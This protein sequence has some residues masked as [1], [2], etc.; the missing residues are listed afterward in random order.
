MEAFEYAIKKD[1]R[2]NP[3]VREVGHGAAV[4]APQAPVP[5][6]WRATLKRRI[7]VVTALLG[8]WVAG[9]EARLVNLQIFQHAELI[10]RAERQQMR[11]QTVPPKRGDI[12]DRR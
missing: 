6:E 7:G 2:N 8:L 9:I 5:V 12:L 1:V 4:M 3:I 10:A 11:T